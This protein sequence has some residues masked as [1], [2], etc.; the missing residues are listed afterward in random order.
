[1]DTFLSLSLHSLIYPQAVYTIK[2]TA[3]VAV[4]EHVSVY[5]A[6]SEMI[7]SLEQT[8]PIQLTSTKADTPQGNEALINL[9]SKYNYK[10]VVIFQFSQFS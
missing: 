4:C 1:M 6:L 10:Y 5:G 3:S 7:D 9:T 8:L 2:G